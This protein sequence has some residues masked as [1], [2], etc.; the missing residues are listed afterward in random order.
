[1]KQTIDEMVSVWN[2]DEDFSGVITVSGPNSVLYQKAFGYRNRAEKLPNNPD[3]AFAIASGTKLFT[4]LAVCKLIDDGLLTLDDLICDVIVHD[5]K[6]I[7]NKITVFH[8][9]THTSGV[10]DYID[11]EES[12]E[13]YDILKLYE[14]RPVHKW[15]SLAFYLSAFNGLPQ[16]FPPGERYGYSNA[17][18]VLLGLVIEG[19]SKQSYQQYVKDKIIT[20]LGLA[21]TGFYRMNCLPGNTA[22]GYHFNEKHN[23]YEMNT[24]YMPIVG[25]SDGGIFTC[26]AD[27]DILWRAIV[28]HRLLSV[29]MTRQLLTAH[30]ATDDE[31]HC[32]LGV[33]IWECDD[34]KA[35]Y[36][37]GGDFGVDYFSAYF[38]KSE[39]VASALGNTEE[40]TF[41]IFE[42][43]FEM[44]S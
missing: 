6:I 17:G 29:E 24:L 19:A 23:E 35:F 32:G 5:L 37:V 43:L 34:K 9:L 13:Y 42:E 8:L 15:D 25:G 16:K 40:N 41:D 21:H 1:M 14:N 10:G 7:N 39:I 4:S 36:S 11:E 12:Q 18:F 33:F 28:S 30:V 44:L 3:T 27:I 22:N 20:P 31:T 38:P 26:A 2:E